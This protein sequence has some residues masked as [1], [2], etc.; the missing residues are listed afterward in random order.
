MNGRTKK[1]FRKLENNN[2]YKI[3]KNKI[4]ELKKNKKKLEK[5]KNKKI[6]HNKIKWTKSEIEKK[7]HVSSGPS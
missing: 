6:N 3:N 1:A 2:E 4:T 5:L 7:T